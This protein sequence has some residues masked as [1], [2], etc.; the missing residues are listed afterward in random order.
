MNVLS[1]RPLTGSIAPQAFAVGGIVAGFLVVYSC[2]WLM[3]IN[4]C[5]WHHCVFP[6]VHMKQEENFALESYL[7]SS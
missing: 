6:K 3:D 7:D 4:I 5:K 1:Q 2:S